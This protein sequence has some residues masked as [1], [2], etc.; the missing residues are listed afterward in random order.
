[1]Y[2]YDKHSLV[3]DVI[4]AFNF[5]NYVSNSITSKLYLDLDLTLDASIGDLAMITKDS[6]EVIEDT[7]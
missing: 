5:R 4:D 1:M 2:L 7:L 6:K 3:Y